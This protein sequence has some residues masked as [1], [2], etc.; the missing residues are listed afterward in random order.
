MFDEND[1]ILTD[2]FKDDIFQAGEGKYALQRIPD[3]SSYD[4]KTNQFYKKF[5]YNNF[6]SKKSFLFIF[7][8]IKIK[9]IQTFV[10]EIFDFAIKGK[11]TTQFQ[12][13]L[14]LKNNMY[15]SCSTF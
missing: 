2:N 14:H 6:K 15:D 5:L 11:L 1:D 10:I 4:G 7:P 8:K 9:P 13:T 3:C 12:V